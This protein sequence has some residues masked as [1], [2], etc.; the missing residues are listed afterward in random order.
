MSLV[1]YTAMASSYFPLMLLP[2]T[3]L[4]EI[5]TWLSGRS[6]GSIACVNRGLADRCR[7]P[8]SCPHT[9]ICSSR[10]AVAK[11][12]G[13]PTHEV[14]DYEGDINDGE[15]E[16]AET[17]SS[18]A[19]I[20]SG[21]LTPSKI[22]CRLRRLHLTDYDVDI[23][24]LSSLV[25]LNT[26]KCLVLKPPTSGTATN[27]WRQ[28]LSCMPSLT[29]LSWSVSSMDYRLDGGTYRLFNH[30]QILPQSLR[31]FQCPYM[32]LS[33][34][35]LLPTTLE[36]LYVSSLTYDNVLSRE[37][38]L[39][40]SMT[41]DGS[42]IKFCSNHP[43]LTEF[44]TDNLGPWSTKRWMM[45][46]SRLAIMIKYMPLLTN[47]S[48][49]ATLTKNLFD[50]TVRLLTK[51]EKTKD[52]S[53]DKVHRAV[54]QSLSCNERANDVPVGGGFNINID[55]A[56]D[57][58]PLMSIG[59]SQSL[60]HL[61]LTLLP[62]YANCLSTLPTATPNLLSLTL[63]SS[64]PWIPFSDGDL[65]PLYGTLST[66]HRRHDPGGVMFNRINIARTIDI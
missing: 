23:S 54:L 28:V 26:L 60:L 29:S 4:D 2:S 27:E 18:A 34:M 59:M 6:H 10:I 44:I 45:N 39:I 16:T 25:T 65:L 19:L 35:A 14:D 62:P 48:M 40:P 9:L 53:R 37:E 66:T 22:T 3:L 57:L 64:S 36:S 21:L 7:S 33:S 31:H 52:N 13:L 56:F 46:A 24:S 17:L 41:V 11:V 49:G 61:T 42:W 32:S 8:S 15:R 5:L 50:D 55:A 38:A 12:L 47:I 51:D 20:T 1:M 63:S 43:K 30:P 58:T